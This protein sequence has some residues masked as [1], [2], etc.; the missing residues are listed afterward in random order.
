MSG[1]FTIGFEGL[2]VECIIGINP[3]ERVTPQPL[4]I[5]LHVVL[6]SSSQQIHDDTSAVGAA[7]VA[8]VAP[9]QDDTEKGLV[10]NYST[11]AAKARGLAIDGQFGLLETF[12][13]RLANAILADHRPHAVSVRVYVRKPK[14]LADAVATVQYE[15]RA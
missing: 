1:Q 15:A 2:A 5:D 11:L 3:D 6:R 8:G 10:V 9:P 14:A 4:L 12:A 7:A 13:A